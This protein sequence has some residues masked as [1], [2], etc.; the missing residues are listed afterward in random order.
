[1]RVKSS[2]YSIEKVNVNPK[3]E[4][5]MKA[6]IGII[7]GT[8]FS[9]IEG[10]SDIKKVEIDTPFG[11]PSDAFVLGMLEGKRVVFVP[12]HG[13]GHRLLPSEINV[14]AN[15]YALKSLG[16]E[17]IISVSSVGSLREEICPRDFVIP[18][19]LYDRTK[20]R[21]STFFGNGLVAHISF[22]QPFCP[23]LTELLYKAAEEAGVTVHKGGTYICMEGPQFS[24]EAESQTYR[25][26][27][28]DIIGMTVAPE[29][30]L[31]REAEICYATFACSTDY[32]CWHPSYDQVSTEMII[33]NLAANI[34]HSKQSV[35]NAIQLIPTERSDCECKDALKNA[36]VTNAELVPQK[37][38]DKLELLAGKYL[39]L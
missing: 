34:E 6:K 29:A 15:I 22:A 33:K 18:D 36:I 30:K 13:K 17:W 21:D 9:E 4:V 8:G 19:Q 14:R 10:L 5:L 3:G 1:M 38:K 11:K 28:F 26:L 24:T 32:D 35:K 37:T 20:N 7:G 39:N 23:V 16:V 2:Q 27:G 12:R 25:K 31:A